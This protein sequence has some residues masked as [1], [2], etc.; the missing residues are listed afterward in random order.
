METLICNEF[1]NASLFFYIDRLM[2]V[3]SGYLLRSRNK[4]YLVIVQFELSGGKKPDLTGLSITIWVQVSLENPR[5]ACDNHPSYEH[6]LS[7]LQ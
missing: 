2:A 4:F 1:V 3:K 7:A 5:V 6:K